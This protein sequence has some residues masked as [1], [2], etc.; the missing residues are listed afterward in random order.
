MQDQP[1]VRST[2]IDGFAFAET[3][4]SV[5]GRW[6]VSKLTRLRDLV[7]SSEGE[8]QY[9]VRGATVEFGRPALAVSVSGTL[10]LMCQRCLKEMGF[11]LRLE[12]TLILAKSEAE[13]EA[14]PVDP[15]GPDRV[16]GSREMEVGTLLEDEILLAIP[17]APRHERCSGDPAEKGEAQVSPFAD[18]RGLLNRGGRAGN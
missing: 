5:R 3:G 15:E 11:P 18:L 6:A 12:A 10:Q 8:L 4:K 7:S 9:E 2:L 17:F 13:I 16:V 14:Q 1:S